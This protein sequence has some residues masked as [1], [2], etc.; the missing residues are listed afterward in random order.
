[1]GWTVSE[2]RV[3]TPFFIVEIDMWHGNRDTVFS[4]MGCAEIMRQ[5]PDADAPKK[6]L[7]DAITKGL[8]YLGFNADIFLGK[9]DDNKYV[10]ERVKEEKD[11]AKVDDHSEKLITEEIQK[12]ISNC[13]TDT[14]LNQVKSQYKDVI[15]QVSA[16]ARKNLTEQL[17]TKLKNI[18]EG[19][20][21]DDDVPF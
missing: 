9:F 1:W 11:K 5:R 15:S 18:Q 8:S 7:T 21:Y 3:E 16:S 20:P 2:W 13:S 4:V 6:A 14:E 17:K 19:K 12:A 10:Q